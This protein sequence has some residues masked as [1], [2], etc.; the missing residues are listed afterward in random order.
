MSADEE[1]LMTVAD[2]ARKSKMH[3]KTVQKAI[4]AGRL[5]AS[6]LGESGAY[7]IRPEWYE[8]WVEASASSTAPTA[9]GSAARSTRS[10]RP[11][12]RGR[13]AVTEGM[14]KA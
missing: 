1:E 5:R 12:E 7:R 6:R 11:R 2:V 3:P 13:L 9:T 8:Q 4:R 10:A 14:G